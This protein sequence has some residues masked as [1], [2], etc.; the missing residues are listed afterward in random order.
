MHMSQPNGVVL[1]Y[2]FFFD[3]LIKVPLYGHGCHHL[4]YIIDSCCMLISSRP[5]YHPT[6]RKYFE[7]RIRQA[8]QFFGEER[9]VLKLAMLIEGHQNIK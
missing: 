2:L 9:I 8:R 5:L 1:R 3:R 4:A 6:A 7:F